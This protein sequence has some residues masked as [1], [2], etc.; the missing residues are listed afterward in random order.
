MTLIEAL[1][2]LPEDGQPAIAAREAVRELRAVS[3]RFVH[4]HATLWSLTPDGQRLLAQFRPYRAAPAACRIVVRLV[5]E[6]HGP[7]FHLISEVGT[8]RRV[9]STDLRRSLQEIQGDNPGVKIVF[10]YRRSGRVA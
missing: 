8:V 3:D 10:D 9:R 1:L 7:M 5:T 4:H 2:S 6:P